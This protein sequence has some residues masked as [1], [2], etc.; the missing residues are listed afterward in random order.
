MFDIG[1]LRPGVAVAP[2]EQ[3]LVTRV[4]VRRKHDGALALDVGEHGF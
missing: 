2:V 4:E 3:T 1:T